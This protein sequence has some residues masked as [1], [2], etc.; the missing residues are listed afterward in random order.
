MRVT[1]LAAMML[2][3][4]NILAAQDLS[5]AARCSHSWDR[6]TISFVGDIL[7]HRAIYESVVSNS[8]RFASTW[9]RAIPYFTKADFS[10]ANLE[11][12]AA[13]GI[14]AQ[15]KDHG[16]IGFVYDGVVYSGTNFVFNYHP[17]ILA[18]LVQSGMDL[19]TLA[20]NHSLDRR[21]IGVDR[22]LQA[23]ESYKM[24][25]VGTRMSKDPSGDFH[26]VMDINHIRVAFIGCTEM[27]NGMPDPANQVLRCYNDDRLMRTIKDLSVRADVD[28]VIVYPHWGQEYQPAPDKSQKLYAR[29]YLEAGA[30]AVVGS[31]PHVL[32]P[33]E[34]YRTKDG[35][36]T[37]IAY[38]LGNFLAGQPGLEK[39]T[40]V[41]IYL[42]LS[43]EG[44]GKAKVFGVGYT[45]TYRDGVEIYPIESHGNPS[46]LAHAAK[47]FGTNGRLDLATTLEQKFCN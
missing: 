30:T 40:G 23:A 19:L 6:A 28:A 15:G 34:I 45:P 39:Q 41:I 29:K 20:N 11:G 44:S 42:G 35:R 18:E 9:K 13:M 38:S 10:V 8:K 1:V 46:V 24:P 25:T 2:L 4:S 7:V 27:T 47:F 21:S 31:H 36:E 43:K 22:T 14:D 12:P 32:Q 17:Q 16:D 5:F 33:W 3:S 37:L 26:R